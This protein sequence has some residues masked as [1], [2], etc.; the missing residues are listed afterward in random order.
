MNDLDKM[1]AGL[2]HQPY[3]PDLVQVRSKIKD[4]LFDYNQVLRPSQKAERA[5]LIK[6]ILGKTQEH[7]KINSPFH[8]DYGFRIEVGENFFANC[9]CVMLDS[10]G[11]QIGNNVLFGPN[12]SLY[13][14]E[15]PLHPELRQQEWEHGR[16]IIIGNNVWVSGSV[17]IIGG[18]TIGDNV[19]IGAGSVVTKNIP[20]NS[21]AVG[22]PC[23]VIREISEQD[24]QFYLDTYLKNA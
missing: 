18:V 23:R 17:T 5:A 9:G 15:H 13:S 2:A 16:A 8:C 6:Q 19:V 20:A 12:V 1:L 21:L 22:N 10:G 14:V 11:I 4:M 7:L 24:R 3:H